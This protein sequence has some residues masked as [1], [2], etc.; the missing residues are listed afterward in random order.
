VRVLKLAVVHFRGVGLL[1]RLAAA[2][3][4]EFV[5]LVRVELVSLHCVV[6]RVRRDKRAALECVPMRKRPP[7]EA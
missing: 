5:F 6:S 2:L 3:R 1:A 4:V 7:R